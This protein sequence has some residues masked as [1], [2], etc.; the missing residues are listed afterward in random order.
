MLML[1]GQVANIRI[2]QMAVVSG[3]SFVYNVVGGLLVDHVTLELWVSNG[4][5]SQ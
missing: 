4:G 1:I 5:K 3:G 2:P